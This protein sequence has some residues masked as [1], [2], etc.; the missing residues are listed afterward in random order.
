MDFKELE[1]SEKAQIIS[2]LKRVFLKK[3]KRKNLEL[4]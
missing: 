1:M 3:M 4:N 2:F